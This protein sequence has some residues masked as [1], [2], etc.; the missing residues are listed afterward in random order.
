MNP[1]D[2]LRKLVTQQ[3]RFTGRVISLS[4][5]VATVATS[6]GPMTAKVSGI[7]RVGQLVTVAN[8]VASGLAGD[9]AVF[10]V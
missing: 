2:E 9:V 5:D 8:G 3:S 7:V 1:L 4:G 10:R 6:T